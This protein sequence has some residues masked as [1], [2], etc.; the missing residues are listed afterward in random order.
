MKGDEFMLRYGKRQHRQETHNLCVCV[1]VCVCARARAS[2]CVC[3]CVCVSQA[4]SKA[5]NLIHSGVSITI[6]RPKRGYIE[7]V[8]AR[9]QRQKVTT[10][11]TVVS[12]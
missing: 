12:P 5:D 10:S 11:S 2:V 7:R 8:S 9:K 4:A 3:V 6:K 1:C